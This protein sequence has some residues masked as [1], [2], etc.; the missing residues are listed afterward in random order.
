[1]PLGWTSP[2][3]TSSLENQPCTVTPLPKSHK[4]MFYTIITSQSSRSCPRWPGWTSSLALAASVDFVLGLALSPLL[5]LSTGSLSE[6]A[7]SSDE[8]IKWMFCVY[9]LMALWTFVSSN[10]KSW[11]ISNH[12]MKT[13]CFCFCHKSIIGVI[14]GFFFSSYL[15]PLWIISSTL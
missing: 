4:Q 15:C 12:E 7:R 14:G 5:R 11:K 13:R 10:L 8:I 1:M 3:W 9:A 2:L 6:F